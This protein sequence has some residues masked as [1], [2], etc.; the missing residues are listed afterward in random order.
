MHFALYFL[1]AHWR[2]LCDTYICQECPLPCQISELTWDSRFSLI[3]CNHVQLLLYLN[4]WCHHLSL[5][6]KPL[7]FLESFFSH[8]V[9]CQRPLRSSTLTSEVAGLPF[10]ISLSETFTISRH[11]QLPGMTGI[12]HLHYPPFISRAR[13]QS[14][15]LL[16]WCLRVTSVSLW[17]KI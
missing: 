5:C 8:N 4:V 13:C 11:F 14:Q 2:S 6:P 15:C 12:S 7:V 3:L 9:G 10:G 16:V 1:K 17:D